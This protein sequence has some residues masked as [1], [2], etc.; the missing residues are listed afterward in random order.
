[1]TLAEFQSLVQQNAE[2][3]QGVHPETAD[4]IAE[5]ERRIGKAL[6]P[7]LKWLLVEWGYSAVRGV[8]SLGD[9]VADT[10]RL[11]ESLGLPEQYV[12]LNDWQDRGVVFFDTALQ[13]QE[14]EHSIYWADTHN[15]ERLCRHEEMDANVDA[16]PDFPAWIEFR[17]EEVKS[18]NY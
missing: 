17:L 18:E 3:F 14:G 16:F 5:A 2:W 15:I 9:A 12:I 6:P 7:S 8:D 13:N 11:R 1:M 4:S 10:L